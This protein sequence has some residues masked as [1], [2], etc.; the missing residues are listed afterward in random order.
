M[1]TSYINGVTAFLDASRYP[2]CPQDTS[3]LFTFLISC[4]AGMPCIILSVANHSTK[5][6]IIGDEG[7]IGLYRNSHMN[8]SG[9]IRN[10]LQ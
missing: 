5:G 2:Y 1:S 6:T 4:K 9:I 3:W 7:N 8:K 10:Y